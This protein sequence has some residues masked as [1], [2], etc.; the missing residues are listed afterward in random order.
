MAAVSSPGRAMSRLDA[1]GGAIAGSLPLR[2]RA[3][4]RCVRVSVLWPE[5]S[6]AR[7]AASP[8]AM[9]SVAPSG[10]RPVDARWARTA[11]SPSLT[12]SSPRR[13]SA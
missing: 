5:R 8:P 3:A 6:Q 9:P 2:A 1:N 11:S 4:V 10:A 13:S 7:T 12:T